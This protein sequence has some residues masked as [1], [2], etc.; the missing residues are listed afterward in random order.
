M[1]ISFAFYLVRG[2]SADFSVFHNL[3]IPS[4][5][6]L[7]CHQCEQ[8]ARMTPKS[9]QISIQGILTIKR[10]MCICMYIYQNGVTIHCDTCEVLEL[11]KPL[12]PCSL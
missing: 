7:S 9:F 8:K 1:C 12:T 11:G 2:V 5:A 10:D 6:T 4:S 3:R